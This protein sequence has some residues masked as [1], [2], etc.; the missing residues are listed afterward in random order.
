MKEPVRIAVF[1]SGRGSNFQALHAVLHG[2]E[3]APANIV[4]CISNNPNPGAFE[5]AREAGIESMR[6]SPKMYDDEQEYERSLLWA[7][8]E[9][10]IELI[11]LAGY[12]RQLPGGVVRAYRGRILNIHPALLPLHGGRGMFGMYVHEAV[13]A[14]GETE[15]GATVHLADEEYDTGP[16]IAQERVPVLPGDTPETLAA[17]V[18]EAEHRLYPAT[19]MMWAEKLRA[20]EIPP[21]VSNG[22]KRV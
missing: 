16:I 10:D 9:R 13:L 12:M 18:L 20:G 11:V 8:G 17:R 5:F 4:L 1:A 19:V 2:M 14:A 6:L 21:T 3:D 7:L 22:Q 15:S